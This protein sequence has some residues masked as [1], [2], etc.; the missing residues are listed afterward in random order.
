M[1]TLNSV[2]FS[3]SFFSSTNRTLL[4]ALLISGFNIKVDWLMHCHSFKPEASLRSSS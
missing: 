2:V 4:L 3:Q 1:E